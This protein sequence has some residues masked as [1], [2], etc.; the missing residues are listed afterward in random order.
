M[1]INLTA[2][3]PSTTSIREPRLTSPTKRRLK[4]ANRHH[5]AVDIPTVPYKFVDS[6]WG[7]HGRSAR[8][9]VMCAQQCG[10]SG[11]PRLKTE[12][13]AVAQLGD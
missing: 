9:S 3:C 10:R 11:C 8:P 7:G 1:R 2:R 5:S 4:D 12:D 6:S 13:L